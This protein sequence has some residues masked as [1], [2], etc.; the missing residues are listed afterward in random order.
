MTPEIFWISGSW[1]GRLAVAARPQG[2]D[3][4]EDEAR[5]WQVAGLGI[6]VSL[7]KKDEAAELGLDLERDAARSGRR[8]TR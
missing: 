1:R 5:G 4:L 6:V 2:G 8:R 7:L 3:W